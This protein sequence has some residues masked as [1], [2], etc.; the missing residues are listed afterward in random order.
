MGADLVDMQLISKFNKGIRPLLCVIEIYSEYAWVISLNDK[1][2]I[3]ITNAFQK[4][5][6]ES[7]SKPNK[8]W[9]NKRSEFYNRSMKSWLEKKKD[10]E[11]YST[12][13]E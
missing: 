11:M 7:N 2:G 3:T 6:K 5:L 10:F 4:I 9:F 13:N 8:I 12:H 1:K